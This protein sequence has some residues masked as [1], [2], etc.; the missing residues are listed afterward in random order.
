MNGEK[1]GTMR[2]DGRRGEGRAGVGRMGRGGTNG[3]REI[4]LST[5][6]AAG[7]QRSGDDIH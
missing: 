6:D 7:N 2:E 4:M 3:L 5:L 1:G